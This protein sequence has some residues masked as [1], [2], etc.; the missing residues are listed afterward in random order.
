MKVLLLGATGNLGLRLVPALLAHQH[1]VVVYVRNVTKLLSLLP[2]SLTDKLDIVQGDAMNIEKMEKTMLDYSCE[3]VVNSAGDIGKDGKGEVG[4]IAQAVSE[5]AIVAGKKMGKPL[6]AWFLAGMSL[7]D[8]PG[9]TNLLYD[10]VPVGKEHQETWSSLHATSTENLLWSLLC[11]SLMVPISK[12]ISHTQKHS[13]IA[14]A[15][16]PPHWIEPQKSPEDDEAKILRANVMSN[17]MAAKTNLEDDADFIAEDLEFGR[18]E[19]LGKKV[20][21]KDMNL[22]EGE[23]QWPH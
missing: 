13:L 17:Y 4:K 6:R 9:S 20:G 3:A 16:V 14:T 19:W 10:Y 18:L 12:D 21:I 23:V 11:P 2:L 15:S 1:E 22:T 7:L 8:Y 5:A